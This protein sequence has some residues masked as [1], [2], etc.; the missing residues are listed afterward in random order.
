MKIGLIGSHPDLDKLIGALAARRDTTVDIG[1]LDNSVKTSFELTR[2][3]AADQWE[4]LLDRPDLEFVLVT[5]PSE[6]GKREFEDLLRKFAQ[7]SVPLC[8]LY[9][10]CDSI[11]AYEIEMIRV[12]HGGFVVPVLP[13]ALSRPVSCLKEWLKSPAT[14]PLGSLQHVT[15]QRTTEEVGATT[16]QR[17]FAADLFLMQSLVG[18]ISRLSAVGPSH[19]DS[20]WP[21]LDVHVISS[22]GVILSWT[23][24]PTDDLRG[25]RIVFAGE[26]A[27][28][29]LEI[30][31]EG[32]AELRLQGNPVELESFTQESE[33]LYQAIRHPSDNMDTWYQSARAMEFAESISYCLRRGRGLDIPDERPS[34]HRSFKGVMSMASCGI[35]LLILLALGVFVVI[36]GVQYPARY[37][38]FQRQQS[39]A[40]AGQAPEPAQLQP[41]LV[42]I[43]PVY[44]IL[45]FLVLQLLL[46]LARRHPASSAAHS[47]SP[48][49]TS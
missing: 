11:L 30:D 19:G 45:G 47:S 33:Q 9:P 18:P 29:T 48:I 38:E 15:M 31:S 7:S 3:R 5:K 26:D 21:H 13:E 43:W 8:V 40:E 24:R 42:R 23:N 16:V 10:A 25:A 36:E 2:R 34:E 39:L 12:E 20:E 41:F 27:E 14:S 37:N 32:A 1:C 4:E 22:A 35:L 28:A 49:D 44:P 6:L 46:L 17:Q